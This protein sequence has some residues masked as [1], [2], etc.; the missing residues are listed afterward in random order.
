MLRNVFRKRQNDVP[1]VVSLL[2]RWVALAP[3]LVAQTGTGGLTGKVPARE[4]R[5]QMPP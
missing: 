2:C 4:A 3:S 5:L 1:D